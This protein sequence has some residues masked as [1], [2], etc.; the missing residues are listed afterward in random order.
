MS[1]LDTP[2]PIVTSTPASKSRP[3]VLRGE[4]GAMSFDKIQPSGAAERE[5]RPNVSRPP[6]IPSGFDF[7]LAVYAIF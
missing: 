6:D 2:Q 7:H 4:R 1:I 3:Y 5:Q